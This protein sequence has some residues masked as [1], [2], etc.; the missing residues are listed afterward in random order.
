MPE[1]TPEKAQ[2]IQD[3]LRKNLDDKT[4]LAVLCNEWML[5]NLDLR[6]AALEGRDITANVKANKEIELIILGICHELGI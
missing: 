4:R 6:I 1:I 3:Y 5:I 2:K